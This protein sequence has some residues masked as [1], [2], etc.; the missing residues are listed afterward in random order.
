METSVDTTKH[1]VFIS[2]PG[3]GLTP[4]PLNPEI[5]SHS[6]AFT[7]KPVSNV[8]GNALL[9]YT[10]VWVENTCLGGAWP[11]TKEAIAGV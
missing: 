8:E 1:E 11:P 6:L 9:G 7:W 5:L 10:M 4:F 3:Y 2:G